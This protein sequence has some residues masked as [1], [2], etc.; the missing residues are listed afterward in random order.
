DARVTHRPALRDRGVL[1]GAYAL[2]KM[3]SG[4]F[5]IEWMPLEELE[6]VR[7]AA[8]RGDR[9][10]P[11]YSQW[12]DQ[13]Y[14]KA[15]I[16]RLS[17]RLPLGEEF[18]RAAKADELADVGDMRAYQRVIDVEGTTAPIDGEPRAEVAPA[19][20]GAAGVKDRLRKRQDAAEPDAPAAEE[21]ES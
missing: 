7:A 10:S 6:R 9:E 3:V 18:H 16:R 5:E 12:A 8:K 20:K 21:A 19:G 17:K 2:A 4:E 14:R 15:P 1:V 11:A 13:M